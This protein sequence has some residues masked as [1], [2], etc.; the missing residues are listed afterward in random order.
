MNS[1]KE[2][3]TWAYAAGVI[4]FALFMA[5]SGGCL[6]YAA[7]PGNGFWY[8]PGIANLVGWVAVAIFIFKNCQNKTK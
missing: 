5:A 2:K 1:V 3:K 4:A 7:I 6:N 8:V